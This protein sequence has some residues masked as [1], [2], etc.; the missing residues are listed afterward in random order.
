MTARKKPVPPIDVARVVSVGRDRSTG[1]AVI[2]F[3]DQKG[4]LVAIRLRPQQLR[5]L[6]NGLLALREALEDE[7]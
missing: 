5:T 3:W 2:R 4:R 6:A 7:G 1:K